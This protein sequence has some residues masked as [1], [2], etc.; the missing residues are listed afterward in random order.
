MTK[1]LSLEMT[2]FGLKVILKSGL[3]KN[4]LKFPS[5][6]LLP[7][8]KKSAQLNWPVTLKGLEEFQNNFF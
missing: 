1:I 2:I 4:I 8:A 5:E 3:E 6:L 7:G